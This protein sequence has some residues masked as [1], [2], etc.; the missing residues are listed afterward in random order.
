MPFIL[1]F[2][3]F[4]IEKINKKCTILLKGSLLKL[5]EED[6]GATFELI[7]LA[8]NI[9]K[10]VCGVLNSFLSFL[11]KI[12][13][14]KTHNILALMLDLKLKS[15]RLVSFFIGSDQGI[16][17]V[18]KCDIMSL[19]PL[20]MKCYYHLHPSIESKNGFVD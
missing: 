19:Y 11:K 5:M 2:H 20:L 6:L 14:R 13:E 10:E 3:E 4:E 17:I 16:V 18:E 1:P 7:C 9:R 8:S 15:P 12:D